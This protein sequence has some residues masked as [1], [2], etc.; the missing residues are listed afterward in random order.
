MQQPLPS[1]TPSTTASTTATTAYTTATTASTTATSSA[2]LIT[3][4]YTSPAPPKKKLTKFEYE[5]S[6]A[7]DDTEQTRLY[8]LFYPGYKTKTVSFAL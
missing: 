6:I 8:N 1:I 5:A 2:P 4:L 3:K 7:D